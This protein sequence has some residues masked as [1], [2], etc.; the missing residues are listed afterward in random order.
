MNKLNF[1][2]SLPDVVQ[3]REKR[4]ETEREISRNL[5]AIREHWKAMQSIP[6]IAEKC[7]D[8]D[9]ACEYDFLIEGIDKKISEVDAMPLPI[10]D[11]N[12]VICEWKEIKRQVQYHGEKLLE[13]V[14]YFPCGYLLI[15]DGNP[16]A[17]DISQKDRKE[18]EI[19][20]ATV[21]VPDAAKELYQVFMKVV[22][23][24]QEYEKYQFNKNLN[25]RDFISTITHIRDAEEFAKNWISGTWKR[26]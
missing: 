1:E 19:K 24:A 5:A 16:D 26:F 18:L 4:R 23:A 3:V 20:G 17:V 22:E 15:E 21:A 9:V 2:N 12:E 8:I 25:V 10:T 6:E 7:K 11:K 13:A 14:D